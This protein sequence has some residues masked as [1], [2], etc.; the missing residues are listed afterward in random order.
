[1]YHVTLDYAKN[2][3][4]ELCDQVALEAQGIGIVRDNRSYILLTQEDWESLI[5]TTELL[6]VPN[7]LEDVESAREDYKKGNTLIL[8]DIYGE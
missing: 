3:L 8:E 2:H 4:D 7:L 5:E 6:Q 1:M